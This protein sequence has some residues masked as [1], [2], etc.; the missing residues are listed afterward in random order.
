MKTIFSA[1]LT[2]IMIGCTLVAH[3]TVL[4]V[5]N[6][7]AITVPYASFQAAYDVAVN[8]D[9]IYL[10][11]SGYSYG[12]LNLYK[13][14]VII[15]PGYFLNQNPE[16]Q[17]N[18]ASAGVNYINLYAGSSGTKIAGL[19]I[20]NIAHQAYGVVHQD[21]VIM[22]NKISGSMSCP[23]GP[24]STNTYY[25]NFVF[26][27]NFVDGSLSG[28]FENAVFRNNVFTGG[29]T[30]NSY[31]NSVAFFNNVV[32]NANITMAAQCSNNIFFG[33]SCTFTNCT[34]YNNVCSATQVPAGNSNQQNVDMNNV[35]ACYSSCTGYSNDARYQLKAGSP[36]IGA[37]SNG[38]DCGV[39]GG[40]DPYVLSRMPPIPAIYYFN[41]NYS[42]TAINVNMKV[43]SH[44]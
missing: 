36:A 42:N 32:G 8:G 39:F 44:N 33:T 25:S 31:N 14:L 11:G 7:P 28:R 4:R 15:G 34:L 29:V 5:N 21:I 35:F 12:N 18:I 6:T 43:K 26:E 17:A 27:Q 30:I 9:T 1:L 13:S 2:A 23:W 38:E 24:Y 16:T 3:S 20:N 40:V 37:G 41:Y 19:D 22:R 10:E